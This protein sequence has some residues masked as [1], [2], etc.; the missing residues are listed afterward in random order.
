MCRIAGIFDPSLPDISCEIVKMRDA[1]RHGGPDDEGTYI[2]DTFSLALGHRRLSLIDLTSGGHQPMSD[3]SEQIQIV[4][5]GEIYNYRELRTILK[6][7]G[8]NFS[9][10]SDTEVVLK[11]YRYW[12]I[13]C[14]T[15]FEGMFAIALWDKKKQQIILARDHAGI[16]PLY[17]Y[18]TSDR[19]YFAS[20]IRA[21]AHLQYSFS[22]DEAWRAYF[23]SFGYLPEPHTTLKNVKP[24]EKGSALTI[25]IPS[26]TSSLYHFFK[27]NFS[28]DIKNE[29]DAVQ[30][31]KAK[32]EESVQRHLISD[33][34]IGLFLS[35]GIDSSIL[36][37]IASKHKQA[38]LHTLSVIFEE[39]E[40]TEEK[41]QQIIIQKT[42]AKHRSYLIT[43]KIF[44]EHLPDVLQA[45][46][47]PSIDGI[48]TYFISKYAK[49]YG[50][51]AVLSGLGSD[52]LF[53]GYPSFQRVDRYSLLQ[54]APS[55]LLRLLK[56]INNYQ[57]KKL[58][59]ASL[60]NNPGEYLV[61]RG[62]FT[63]QM[64]AR[65]L[66]ADEGQIV[67]QLNELQN[68]YPDK[69][70]NNENRVSYLETSFYMQNQLLKDS[71]FMSMWHGL[72]IRVPFLDKLLINVLTRI[73]PAIKFKKDLP[74]YLLVK[75][76][77]NE[78]PREIWE[79]KKQGFTFPF[80][81]WLSESD[82]LMPQTTNEQTLYQKF[83]ANKLSWSRYWCALLMNRFDVS[84]LKYHT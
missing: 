68:Y 72:E 43:R 12:G 11:A 17:Y 16:K 58:S 48:N 78:L 25:Q 37:L 67:N 71:D 5:N 2:D 35:G 82:Y 80:M 14:F 24:L 53:G 57:Y 39:K 66:N 3:D 79:R 27:L 22:E 18:L 41:F 65:L 56:Y 76:F 28:A 32:L 29:K 9:T 62:L 52:E 74:K 59:Y 4:F 10:A 63:P 83:S 84:G 61:Y 19:L 60:K 46:D 69:F 36:T 81:N 44:L 55:L 77:D 30:L 73:D 23:L 54:S 49:E 20:E 42:R 75:A 26:L 64:T 21:F 8:F 40:F 50:L 34:P 1:M 70:L 47:Q 7:T 45:M 51:K 33:A 6:N 38:D 31:T 15:Y 13:N